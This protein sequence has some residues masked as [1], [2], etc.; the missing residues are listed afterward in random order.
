M[1]FLWPI[2]EI[3]ADLYSMI[4]CSSPANHLRSAFNGY[5]D[6][7]HGNHKYSQKDVENNELVSVVANSLSADSID[8]SALPGVVNIRKYP[9]SRDIANGVLIKHSY[10]HLGGNKSKLGE[11]TWKGG[12]RHL[13]LQS[14]RQLASTC[15][16]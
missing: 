12:S 9:L 11:R 13:S 10:L 4:S 7:W 1:C 2:G 3:P 15:N 8:L 5:N 14:F 6:I 16:G